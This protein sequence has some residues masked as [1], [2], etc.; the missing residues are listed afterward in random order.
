M[1]VAPNGDA[2]HKNINSLKTS[3]LL[4]YEHKFENGFKFKSNVKAYYDAIYSLRGREKY[5]KDE[6]NELESEVELFDAY[7]EGS[8]SDNLDIKLGRQVVVWGR[9]RYDSY[10]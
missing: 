8:L 10:Y 4:D 7:V 5:S 3:L 2:P 9:V 6:L 1:S